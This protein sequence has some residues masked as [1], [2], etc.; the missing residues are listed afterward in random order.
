M[1]KDLLKVSEADRD[2]FTKLNNQRWVKM[3]KQCRKI[4]SKLVTLIEIKSNKWVNNV[5]RFTLRVGV[6]NTTTDKK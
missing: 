3:C 4:Y 1:L 2:K 6:S 5:E